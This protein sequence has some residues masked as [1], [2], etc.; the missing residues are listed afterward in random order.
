MVGRRGENH[1]CS[2][3]VGMR[4]FAQVVCHLVFPH[5]GYRRRNWPSNM[6]HAWRLEAIPLQGSNCKCKDLTGNVNVNNIHRY[7]LSGSYSTPP[8]SIS[9][10]I[11]TSARLFTN[12]LHDNPG[13]LNHL[14]MSITFQT[15]SRPSRGENS[16]S[17]NATCIRQSRWF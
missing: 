1:N 6:G 16:H 8:P 9:N 15:M 5:R 12:N 17:Y 10:I 4:A 7:R 13:Y 11:S 14:H 2:E 3:S